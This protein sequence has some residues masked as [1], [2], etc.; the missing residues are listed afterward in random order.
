LLPE[1]LPVGLAIGIKAIV[2]TL[3]P[4]GFQVRP[5]DVPVRTAFLQHGTQG[6]GIAVGQDALK[7]VKE[8]EG[9]LECL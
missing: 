7:V 1:H 2:F 9:K 4:S 5:S 3:F 6:C 8:K